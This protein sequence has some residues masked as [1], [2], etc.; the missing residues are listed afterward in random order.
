MYLPLYKLN[1]LQN[2]L[3][4]SDDLR[5]SK[6]TTP[7]IYSLP[8][9]N[10]TSGYWYLSFFTLLFEGLST[11]KEYVPSVLISIIKYPSFD[12]LLQTD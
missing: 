8:I 4:F 12:Y 2:I 3:L 5:D 9:S 7:F 1:F 10:S 11:C 6:T